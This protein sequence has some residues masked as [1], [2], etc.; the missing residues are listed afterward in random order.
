M[1]AEKAEQL[2]KKTD[3]YALD[4]WLRY[5]GLWK[6]ESVFLKEDEERLAALHDIEYPIHYDLADSDYDEA[7]QIMVSVR[8]TTTYDQ[9]TGE[10]TDSIRYHR[11]LP[12]GNNSDGMDNGEVHVLTIRGKTDPRKSEDEVP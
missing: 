9:E 2:T 7:G 8:S 4:N 11:H 1:L 10:F 12:W 3:L 6:G 5:L